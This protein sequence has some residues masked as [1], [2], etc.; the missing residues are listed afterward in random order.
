MR[1][2]KWK[3]VMPNRTVFR[4]YVDERGSNDIELYD[5]ETDIGESTNVAAGHPDIVKELLE[6]AAQAPQ[7]DDPTKLTYI[8]PPAP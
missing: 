1:Q 6:L 2:G 4:S 8:R 7:I 5:L 3:L